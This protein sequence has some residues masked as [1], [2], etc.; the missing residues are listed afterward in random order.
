M[1]GLNVNRPM[2]ALLGAIAMVVVRAVPMHEAWG[3]IDLP[4]L[5]LLLGLMLLAGTLAELGLFDLVV[6][7]VLRIAPGPRA[8]LAA[9]VLA[10]GVLSALFLNDAV[11]ILFTPVVLALA[12]RTGRAPLPYLLAVA[13]ASNVGG[14]CT[15]TGNPQNALIGVSSGIGFGEFVARLAPASLV[16]L[17]LVYA[18]LAR[19]Y[20]RELLATPVAGA[21]PAPASPAISAV[22][23][24]PLAHPARLGF[25][26]GCTLALLAAFF[27]HADLALAALAAGAL[28][29]VF[30]GPRG[31]GLRGVD[32]STLVLFAGLFIVTE[33]VREAGV[34]ATIA[35]LLPGASG[36]GGHAGAGLASISRLSGVA[37]VLSN[38]VSNVPA[39]MMLRPALA[40]AA[41]KQ[42][43]LALAMASTFAGNLTIVG[44]IANLI[45][46]ET[47]REECPIGFLEYLRIGVP[48][49]VLTTLTGIAVLSVQSLS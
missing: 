39:V 46:A 33:G 35:A 44:S 31:T 49:T 11:C 17:V 45:V 25:A 1:P 3:A 22:A 5:G 7:A 43:W 40:A 37:I 20:R 9:I 10:S 28:A 29:S 2:A 4:T 23:D 15:I 19:I 18:L 13:T 34:T 6:R 30:A 32:F 47:A 26:A 38:L 14:A 24:R 8:M 12:R 48:L 27:A 42:A 21:A 36:A 41:S 16:G